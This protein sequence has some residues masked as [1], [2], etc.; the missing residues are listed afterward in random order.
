MPD[1][2]PAAIFYDDLELGRVFPSDSIEVTAEEI[3][4]WCR[5][6]LAGFKCP[7]NV[8]FG[9]LPKTATGKVQKNVLREQ[10]K[11]YRLPT[12]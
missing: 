12:A 2:P 1:S 10:F 4:K 9:D 6:S 5:A 8:V 11:D 3:I 7:K